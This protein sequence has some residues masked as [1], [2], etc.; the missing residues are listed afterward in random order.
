MDFIVYW[1][2]AMMDFIVYW[3]TAMMDFIVYWK[4]N[5]LPVIYVNVW[6]CVFYAPLANL[7]TRLDFLYEWCNYLVTLYLMLLFVKKSVFWV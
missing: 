1:K 5:S 4:T 7:L 2:T 3:K 6:V